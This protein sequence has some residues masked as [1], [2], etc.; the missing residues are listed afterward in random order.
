MRRSS[1]A[2]LSTEAARRRDDG[3]ERFCPDPELHAQEVSGVAELHHDCGGFLYR[4]LLQQLQTS[5]S[6]SMALAAVL[7]AMSLELH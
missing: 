5:G 1:L 7:Q 3:H 4:L 2:W 6:I